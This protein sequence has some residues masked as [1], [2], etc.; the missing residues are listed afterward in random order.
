M[1]LGQSKYNIL[2]QFE[3]LNRILNIKIAHGVILDQIECRKT[4]SEQTKSQEVASHLM[5]LL[6]IIEDVMASEMC[7]E[8][9]HPS[10]RVRLIRQENMSHEKNIPPRTPLL[11]R[12]AVVC[13]G[14]YCAMAQS[15]RNSHSKNRG[16]NNNNNNNNN[17]LTIMQSTN[18]TYRKPCEQLTYRKPR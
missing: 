10:K 17:K 9:N 4:K 7:F 15:E 14:L 13:R 8:Y 5:E 16:E 6:P 2:D 12:K 3:C 18:K 1:I 11:Y